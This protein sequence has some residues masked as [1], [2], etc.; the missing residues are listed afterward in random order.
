M[1]TLR[2][3][4]A[5][6]AFLVLGLVEAAAGFVALNLGDPPIDDSDLT[7]LG[8]EPAPETN[9]YPCL[10]QAGADVVWPEE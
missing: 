6:G 4:L 5:G 3:I 9:A 7:A 10:Q 8:T 1:R 2:R